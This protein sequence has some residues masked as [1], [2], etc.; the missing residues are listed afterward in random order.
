VPVVKIYWYNDCLPQHTYVAV[1]GMTNCGV[2]SGV[3][4]IA[5]LPT[6]V[7]I[8]FVTPARPRGFLFLYW[9]I[10]VWTS[11]SVRHSFMWSDEAANVSLWNLT[12]IYNIIMAV[13]KLTWCSCVSYVPWS[14]LRY[15]GKSQKLQCTISRVCHYSIYCNTE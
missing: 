2:F 1:N 12:H 14:S 8:S 9:L 6:C 11:L 4:I 10:A 3:F 15:K 13:F 5:E 7:N